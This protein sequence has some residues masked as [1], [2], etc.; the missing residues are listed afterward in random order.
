MV[1]GGYATLTPNPLPEGEGGD[2]QDKRKGGDSCE[3]RLPIGNQISY[4][5]ERYGALLNV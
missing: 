5:R 2:L 4:A 1:V 3:D